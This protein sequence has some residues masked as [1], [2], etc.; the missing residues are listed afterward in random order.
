MELTI[1]EAIRKYSEKSANDLGMAYIE[2][3]CNTSLCFT[4]P[5]KNGVT[6]FFDTPVGEDFFWEKDKYKLE[7]P[8]DKGIFKRLS[9][10]I[11]N[12]ANGGKEPIIPK[13]IR[14]QMHLSTRN[15]NNLSLYYANVAKERIINQ[16]IIANG[17][18]DVE[19]FNEL[20]DMY[21]H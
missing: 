11:L 9:F 13:E 16:F 19:K 4:L 6:L 7:R 21:S 15:P 14:Q 17:G 5:L 2:T 12:N 8:N 1:R 20:L 18:I 10:D 3:V